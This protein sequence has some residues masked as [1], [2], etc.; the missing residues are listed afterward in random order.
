MNTPKE[1]YLL[2]G[3]Q[4]VS[5]QESLGRGRRGQDPDH[6]VALGQERLHLPGAPEE[7]GLG[8]KG[9]GVGVMLFYTFSALF[10]S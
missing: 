1:S 7:T 4:D 5:S 8:V 3:F 9:M 2:S 10:L 6:V